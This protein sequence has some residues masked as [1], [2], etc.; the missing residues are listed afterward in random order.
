MGGLVAPRTTTPPPLD[1]I[2]CLPLPRRLPLHVAGR[3]GTAAGERHDVIDHV[4]GPAVRMTGLP[5][6]IVFRRLTA[7]NARVRTS[8]IRPRLRGMAARMRRVGARVT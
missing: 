8:S 5:H 2:L 6:E 3:V 4:T 7:V 1:P